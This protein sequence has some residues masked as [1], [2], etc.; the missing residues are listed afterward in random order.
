M[1]RLLACLALCSAYQS[2]WLDVGD[3]NNESDRENNMIL[4]FLVGENLIKSDGN[5][6]MLMMSFMNRARLTTWRLLLFYKTFAYVID[7]NL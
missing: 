3:L 6:K 5:E 7:Y 2:P 4:N 1:I